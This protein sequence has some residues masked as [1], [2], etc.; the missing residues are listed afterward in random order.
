MLTACNQFPAQGYVTQ[1]NG[2]NVI[3]GKLEY[4]QIYIKKLL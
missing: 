4:P 1:A 2:I 3:N